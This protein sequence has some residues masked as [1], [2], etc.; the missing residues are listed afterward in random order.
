MDAE[1]LFSKDIMRK[2]ILLSTQRSGSTWVIDML[3]SHPQVK[4][5]EELFLE[6]WKEKPTWAGA[7]D[8]FTWNAYWSNRKAAL[9]ELIKPYFY[10]KYLGRVY[11][12]RNVSLKAVGFKVMYSQIRHHPPLFFCLLLHRI[13]VV[14][15]I[16]KNYLDVILS[17]RAVV[18]RDMPHS[19]DRVDEV[20]IYL[21]PSNLLSILRWKERKVNWSKAIF[22]R[23]GLPY[24]EV[25]YENLV[26]GDEKFDNILNFLG[27]DKGS[28]I[29][30]TSLRKMNKGTHKDLIENYEEI[31]N[32]LEGTRY[33]S[34]IT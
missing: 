12:S 7:K 34:L 21:D 4:A 1:R 3:N 9:N 15:L 22:S 26:S 5:Y 32:L 23:L 28:E 20:K 11:T 24:I 31:R 8:I 19:Y 29:L 13:S 27:I 25:T 33:I 14:H 30:R 18:M 16:R 17:E 6:N 2:F 10:F